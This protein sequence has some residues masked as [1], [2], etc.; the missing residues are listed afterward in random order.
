M[1]RLLYILLYIQDAFVNVAASNR[2]SHKVLFAKHV[3]PYRWVIGRLRAWR[4]YHYAYSKVP[5]YKKFIDGQGKVPKWSPFSISLESIP[6]MDKANYIKKYSIED[7]CYDGVLPSRGVVV[8]ESSG[9]SGQPTSWVRGP[10]EREMVR[11]ILQVVFAATT[12]DKPVFVINAFA[13]GAWATGMNVSASLTEICI[14]KSTGPDIDKIIHTLQEFG[15]KYSYV[16]LGYPPFLKNIADDERID[17]HEYEI[18]AGYGGEGMSE[19]MRR[20][21]LK[22]FNRVTGSYGASDLEINIAI[23]TDLSIKLRQTLEENEPLR[24]E[25]IKTEYGVLPMIFQYNPYDY[26]I[27]TNDSGE[28]LVTLARKENINPRLR[29]N[30]HDRGHVL[31]LRDLKRILKKYKLTNLLDGAKLDLPL[32]FHYGRSDMSIDYYG[33]N[34]TPDSIRQIIYNIEELAP[35]FNTFNLVSVEDKKHNKSM[36]INIELTQ[37]A[38]KIKFDEKALS[39]EVFTK[40]GELNKD[41]YNAYNNTAP[42]ESHPKVHVYEFGSGPFEGGSRKLKNEYIKTDLKY[43]KL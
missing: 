39:S 8:D 5:A 38:K 15:P 11:K 42:V 33:A 7:R 16:L 32:L 28:L 12:S 40:L 34:V 27:E 29:Y 36:V 4:T 23:E 18:I 21:L 35:S 31:R 14:I 43:D 2:R 10:Y 41:F 17:L 25:I 9:S 26:V 30:I 20:Y 24:N 3:E 1:K 37:N 19:G 22:S 6:E 13:L